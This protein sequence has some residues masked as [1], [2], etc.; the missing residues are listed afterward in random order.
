MSTPSKTIND[1]V[2]YLL[3]RIQ[4]D[5]RLAWYFLHTESYSR[6][7]DA[8]AELSGKPVAEVKQAYAPEKST[9][10]YEQGRQEAITE[11][12]S[13]PN[14]VVAKLM[15]QATDQFFAARDDIAITIHPNAGRPLELIF[16]ELNDAL[17]T[18]GGQCRFTPNRH[19]GFHEI[20][21]NIER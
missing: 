5:P 15:D 2:F 16:A 1:A 9:D 20:Q 13:D 18:Q 8:A 12:A 10:P 7:L 6:L 14:S 11:I 21:L 3:N 19:P 4:D 17:D